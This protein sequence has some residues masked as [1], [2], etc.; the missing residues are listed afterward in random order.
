VICTCRCFQNFLNHQRQWAASPL[1]HSLELQPQPKASI[2][3]YSGFVNIAISSCWL[4]IKLLVEN[5][6]NMVKRS[7]RE[8]EI[9]MCSSDH[10][11][12]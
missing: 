6:W 7:Q 11:K 3:G 4:R 10:I 2:V 1:P 12:S 8:A 5:M 9:A